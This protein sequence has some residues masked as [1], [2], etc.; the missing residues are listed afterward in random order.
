VKP[1]RSLLALFVAVLGLAACGDDEPAPAAVVDG[2][3]ITEQSVVDEL[4]AIAGNA[5]YLESLEQSLEQSGLA[6]LGDEEDTFNSAFAA[7][8][9]SRQIQY[10]IVSNEVARRELVVDDACEAAARDELV[11][12]LASF[13]ATGDGDAIYEAFPPAYRDQLVSWNA[14]V[15]ALQGDLAEQPCVN[16]AAIEDYF[17]ANRAEFT[18]VCARHI[19]VATLEE[20]EAIETELAAGADFA[21]IA[22]ER[23]T[24]PGSGAQGGD[25]G[26]AAA[27]GYVE[28]FN[29]AVLSQPIG[30]VGP[31]VESQFGF[32]IVVVDS[33]E[34]AELEDVRDQVTSV[35]ASNVQTGFG[36][37]FNN[38]MSA[39]EVTV[40]A[41]YGTWDAATGQIERPGAGSDDE[42]DS[43][44]ETTTTTTPG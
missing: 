20:A 13:S 35:L 31:P 30:E 33:R 4:E 11:S 18:Q 12:G 14:G 3:E 22:T 24:D 2:T 39:A 28:G 1:V 26:C 19:L 43:T 6:V 17:E 40:D 16:E 23:S 32:H 42:T 34:D 15:L 21:T 7:Q 8:V 9:L 27:G 38:A 36:E 10:T 37:W 44:G 25:L 41:R 5:D 29:E